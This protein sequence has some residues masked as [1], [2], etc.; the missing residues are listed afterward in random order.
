ML[1]QYRQPQTHPMLK[2]IAITF[3]LCGWIGFWAQLT[4][5]FLSGLVLLIDPAISFW[6]IDRIHHY[7]QQYHYE[8]LPD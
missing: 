5:V 1:V 6:S 2:K 4:M 3:R 8:H 7:R